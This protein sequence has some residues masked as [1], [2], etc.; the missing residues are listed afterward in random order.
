MVDIDKERKVIDNLLIH[1]EASPDFEGLFP[2]WLWE[3]HKNNRWKS[4]ENVR[5]KNVVYILKRKLKEQSWFII[6]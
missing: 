4:G 2:E 6:H 1:Y 3:K 5:C